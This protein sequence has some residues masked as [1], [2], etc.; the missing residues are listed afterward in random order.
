[1]AMH[2]SQSRFYENIIGRSREFIRLLLPILQKH[3]PEVEFTE[4]DLYYY[5]NKP[6]MSYIRVEAD[7]LTYPL[8]IMLRY[9]LEKAL[10]SGELAPKDVPA[11]WNQKFKEYFGIEVPSDKVGCLQ[12]V[13]WSGMSFGYFPTYALG[14]AYAAQFYHTMEKEFDVKEAVLSGTT[15]K[16]NDW[17]K[18]HVH[19]FGASK[20][21]KDI[22]LAA[23]NEPFDPHYYVNYLINKYSQ[24][25][26][27]K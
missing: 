17:L 4:D 27:I 2:E 23:T 5:V 19:T 21:P 6:A 9:D 3:I 18:E 15:K 22:L 24:I 7:E 12:D 25:Y 1:M 8:H 11:A 13:H 20:D 14:S 10:M 16:I 26:N